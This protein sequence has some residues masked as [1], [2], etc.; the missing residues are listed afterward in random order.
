MPGRQLVGS[1]K[2]LLHSF[3]VVLGRHI[4]PACMPHMRFLQPPCWH[5]LP[6]AAWAIH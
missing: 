4:V 3:A 1:V 2:S 5:K 6:R